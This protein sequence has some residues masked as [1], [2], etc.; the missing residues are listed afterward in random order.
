M[1]IVREVSST[2]LD[3]LV[4]TEL[5]SSRVEE[6]EEF[7]IRAWLSREAIILGNVRRVPHLLGGHFHLSRKKGFVF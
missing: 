1:G 4:R 7:K 5:F 6:A 3:S 2:P